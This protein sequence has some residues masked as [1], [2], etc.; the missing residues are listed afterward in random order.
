MEVRTKRADAEGGAPFEFFAGVGQHGDGRDGGVEGRA[1][2]GFE[3]LERDV[4]QQLG[5]KFPVRQAEARRNPSRSSGGDVVFP[6]HRV[7]RLDHRAEVVHQGAGPVEDEVAEHG[8]GG[9]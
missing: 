6:E 3:F 2:M 1:E 8:A 5:V 7:G 9:V 4:G